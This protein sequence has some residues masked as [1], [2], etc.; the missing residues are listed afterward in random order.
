MSSSADILEQLEQPE[1]LRGAFWGSIGFH[2]S[3][4]LVI[5]GFSWSGLG[6]RMQWGDPTGGGFGSVAVNPVASI[7]LP[8]RPGPQNP[9][10]SDTPSQVPTPPPKPKAQPKAKA[11]DPKAI[12]LKMPNAKKQPAEPAE[13]VSSPANKLRETQ[14]YRPN[15]VYSTAGQAANSP[16]FN[17]PGGGGVGVGTNS[18]FGTQFGA[19]ATL[20]RDQVAR[21]WKTADL[22]PRLQTAP[23]LALVFTIRRDG[24]LVGGSVKMSQ[25]SGNR[26]LDISAQ[27]AV[28][29]AAPFQ[30][31]P[32]Q[33][34]GSEA[35][36]ELRFELRR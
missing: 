34:N 29:D 25:S 23:P 3:I 33:Y 21:N 8:S 7:P 5:V 36:L 19:Y 16:M 15:Q 12:P 17:L 1:R 11:P 14:Q 4:A 26:A 10:A 2:V 28:F 6:Q 20:L 27:R 18:P 13:P 30:G 22:D 32:S 31:L 9:L 24:S 35:T